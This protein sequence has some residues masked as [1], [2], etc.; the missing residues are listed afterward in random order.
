MISQ[1]LDATLQAEFLRDANATAFQRWTKLLTFIGYDKQSRESELTAQLTSFKQGSWET[2]IATAEQMYQLITLF[3]ENL[4]PCGDDKAALYFCLGLTPATRSTHLSN[5]KKHPG[6][7]SFDKLLAAIKADEEEEKLSCLQRHDKEPQAQAFSAKSTQGQSN[8]NSSNGIRMH[9]ELQARC[10]QLNIPKF[11]KKPSTQAASHLTETI[12]IEDAILSTA[13]TAIEVKESNDMT[14]KDYYVELYHALSTPIS[15]KIEDAYLDSGNSSPMTQHKGVLVSPYQAPPHTF[16]VASGHTIPGS[17]EYG[18]IG[19]LSASHP[20]SAV[21]GVEYVP[22]SAH[23]LFSV[24]KFNNV[25][26]FNKEGLDVWFDS[27]AM[28]GYLGKLDRSDNPIHEVNL[29][30]HERNGTYR[31]L[32]HT[33]STT[34]DQALLSPGTPQVTS[35][36][37]WHA[38]FVHCAHQYLHPTAAIVKG[39]NI[40]GRTPKDSHCPACVKDKMHLAPYHNSDKQYTFIPSERI[41]VDIVHVPHQ[42]PSINGAK[43]AIGLKDKLSAAT[44]KFN[45]LIPAPLGGYYGLPSPN[46]PLILPPQTVPLL[47]QRPGSGPFF[48]KTAILSPAVPEP[49]MDD[50]LT[51]LNFGLHPAV[52]VF[53]WDTGMTALGTTPQLSD[54]HD[55]QFNVKIGGLFAGGRSEM[56]GRIRGFTNA[57]VR[58]EWEYLYVP[59]PKPD[60][61]PVKLCGN[62]VSVCRKTLQV[63]DLTNSPPQTIPDDNITADDFHAFHSKGSVVMN[64]ADPVQ[65]LTKVR[66]ATTSIESLAIHP[67]K[68]QNTSC[69]NRNITRSAPKACYSFVF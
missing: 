30:A 50:V 26:K 10:R 63:P 13:Y 57:R 52:T 62:K 69:N 25:S 29:T 44:T 7:D 8:S 40:Q 68:S 24:S 32:L 65:L 6:I 28:K 61:F 37:I 21:T 49:G 55:S 53:L 31:I 5:W 36:D 11:E 35:E 14:N 39:M 19:G 16:T 58:T 2:I 48:A 67:S 4:T 41:S 1:H 47:H 38:R 3:R 51:R 33:A 60:W 12:D 45:T 43:M 54:L 56:R 9:P 20:N 27:T 46:N 34:P 42:H 17:G 59:T 64:H 18:T 22:S 15:S 23:T 66:K